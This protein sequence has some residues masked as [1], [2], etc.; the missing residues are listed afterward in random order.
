MTILFTDSFDEY[1]A[2]DL[3]KFNSGGMDLR[4]KQR[5]KADQKRIDELME[6]ATSKVVETPLV[7][8]VGFDLSALTDEEREFLR[9]FD[10]EDV[11]LTAAHSQQYDGDGRLIHGSKGDAQ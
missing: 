4:M 5:T 10:I 1:S 8:F 7:N 3:K 9:R 6:R 2:E 11:T